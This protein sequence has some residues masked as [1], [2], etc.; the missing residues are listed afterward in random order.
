MEEKRSREE[1]KPVGVII[2]VILE[3]QVAAAGDPGLHVSEDGL[4]EHAA[5]HRS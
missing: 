5:G 2:L 1:R 4:L 3:D